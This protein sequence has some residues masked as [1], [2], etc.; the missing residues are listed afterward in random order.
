MHV[1]VV[2]QHGVS[3]GLEEVDVPDAQEGQQD[4]HVLVQRGAAEVVVLERRE[5]DDGDDNERTEQDTQGT[6]L[7][8]L[9]VHKYDAKVGTSAASSFFVPSVV[10]LRICGLTSCVQGF[11]RLHTSLYFI[12]M[13]EQ[14]VGTT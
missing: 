12:S 9:F 13:M 2:G 3:L 14:P 11:H 6:R 1:L 4:G 5:E 10:V 7:C 8:V